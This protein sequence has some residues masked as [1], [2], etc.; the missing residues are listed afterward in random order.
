MEINKF[1]VL[2][3][4]LNCANGYLIFDEGAFS[5]TFQGKLVLIELFPICAEERTVASLT[6]PNLDDQRKT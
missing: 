1:F 5:Q 2:Q 6:A 4:F 3:L